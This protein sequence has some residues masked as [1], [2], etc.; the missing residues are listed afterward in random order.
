MRHFRSL[1]AAGTALLAL[2]GIFSA[3]PALAFTCPS[4]KVCVYSGPNFDAQPVSAQPIAYDTF[5]S[6]KKW[7]NP[8][9][10]A[11]FHSITNNSNSIAFGASPVGGHWRFWCYENGKY[12]VSHL[13]LAD[14]PYLY[15]RY[16]VPSCQNQGNPSPPYPLPP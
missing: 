15:I 8:D 13:N 7:R 14:P 5:L 11:G 2:A 1:V 9:F 10:P 12:D 6:N 16:N 4:H 3:A